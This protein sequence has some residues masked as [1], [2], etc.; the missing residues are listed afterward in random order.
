M[1]GKGAKISKKLI[2]FTSSLAP[3]IPSKFISCCLT[4][5]LLLRRFREVLTKEAVIK[6]QKLP[7]NFYTTEWRGLTTGEEL[8]VL[9]MRVRGFSGLWCTPMLITFNNLS[10]SWTSA[11]ATSLQQLSRLQY[12]IA[13]PQQCTVGLERGSREHRISPNFFI[14][15]ILKTVPEDKL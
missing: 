7:T 5:K 14:F 3:A 2:P 13:A 15:F 6:W 10:S 11:G 9:R 8:L 4:W 1:R 12:P